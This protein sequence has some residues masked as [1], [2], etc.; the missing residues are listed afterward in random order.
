MSLGY[1]AGYIENHKSYTP[2]GEL[3][4]LKDILDRFY[5]INV[6]SIKHS[7]INDVDEVLRNTVLCDSCGMRNDKKELICVNCGQTI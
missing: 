5:N 4:S 6:A 1:S 2:T 3:L 7:A